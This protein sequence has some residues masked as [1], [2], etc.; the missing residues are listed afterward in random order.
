MGPRAL[1]VALAALLFLAGEATGK[2]PRNAP[3]GAPGPSPELAP[4]LAPAPGPEAEPPAEAPSPEPVPPPSP[5]KPPT[6]KPSPPPKKEKSP[7]PPPKKT[8]SPAPAKSPN[9]PIVGNSCATV[10]PGQNMACCKKKADVGNWEDQWCIDNFPDLF[11]NDF[12]SPPPDNS[13]DPGTSPALPDTCAAV[14]VEEDQACCRKAVADSIIDQYCLDTY[15]ALYQDYSCGALQTE[16]QRNQ[17]CAAKKGRGISDDFCDGVVLVPTVAAPP[18]SPSPSPSPPPPLEAPTPAPAPAPEVGTLAPAPGPEP[19]VAPV[20][21][22]PPPPAKAN[23]TGSG[24]GNEQ[25]PSAAVTG[26][27]ASFAACVLAAALGALLVA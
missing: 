14:N 9:P 17:C 26:S 25:P 10:T 15:P 7:S 18:P 19:E 12:E 3:A 13:P 6:P 1:C 11:M 5:V 23:A 20:N 27:Q 24:N 22:P 16:G 21:A 2:V 4:I 8:P